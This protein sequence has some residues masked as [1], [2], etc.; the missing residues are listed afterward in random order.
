MSR[1]LSYSPQLPQAA[2]GEA[3][4]KAAAQAGSQ[5]AASTSWT[6]DPDAA[7]STAW[8]SS[9]PSSYSAVNPN[10]T[11][12]QN[13][14]GSVEVSWPNQGPDIWYWFHWQDDTSYPGIWNKNEF[15][16]QGPNADGFVYATPAG[17]K[18]STGTTISQVFTLPT[19][20]PTVTNP[21]DK[22]SFWVQAFA[23]GNG[24]VIS[25]DSLVRLLTHG[26]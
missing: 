22:F 25:P 16:A 6:H 2:R 20:M 26:R 15:W 8:S 19:Q 14:D 1:A 13:P 18:A 21:G 10:I 11:F 23:A 3:P 12:T 7:P 17:A 5:A 24:K 9:C 4:L